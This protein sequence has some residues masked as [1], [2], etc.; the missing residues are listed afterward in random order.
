[1]FGVLFRVLDFP[2][3]YRL[4]QWM[5]APGMEQ[6]L[7]RLFTGL[8][9]TRDPLPWLDIGCG[10]DSRVPVPAG[11]LFGA[12]IS[13]GYVAALSGS[14]CRGVVADSQR[15]PFPGRCFGAVWSVGLFHHLPDG[16]VQDAI[17]EMMRVCTTGG[18]IL[19][20]DG[21]LPKRWWRRPLAHIIRRADRGRFMRSQA[22]LEGML[23]AGV[24]WRTERQTCAWIGLEML[25]CI[26]RPYPER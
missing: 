17:A 14:E 18:V 13:P 4:S 24:E 22:R 8:G 11:G 6:H 16:H 9:D 20:C 10:P 12:D 1:L 19:I 7:D 25:L 3:L 15:L 23:P 2:A 5:L 26:G 21:V